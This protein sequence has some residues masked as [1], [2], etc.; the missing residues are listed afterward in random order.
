MHQCK[1]VSDEA[2]PSLRPEASSLT[3][4]PGTSESPCGGHRL[5]IRGT[6]R[7]RP[8]GSRS[9]PGAIVS[10]VY[11]GSPAPRRLAHRLSRDARRVTHVAM[12][13]NGV[14]WIPG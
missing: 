11:W 1:G 3:V 9:D 6:F 4:G 10:D 5:R 8:G 13:S 7:R 12:E 14:H 2:P